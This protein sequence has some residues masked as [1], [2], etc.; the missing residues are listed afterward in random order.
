MLVSFDLFL[1]NT[2]RQG[3]WIALSLMPFLTGD[4]IFRSSSLLEKSLYNTLHQRII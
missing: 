3:K 2:F 1:E 4:K